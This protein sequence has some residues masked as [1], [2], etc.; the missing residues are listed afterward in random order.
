MKDV[1]ARVQR[2]LPDTDKDRYD[3]AYQRGRAQ[4]RSTLLAGGVAVGSALGAGLMWLLDPAKGAARRAQLGDRF[5]GLRN[6]VSSNVGGK[7]EDIGN[8]VSGFAIERGIKQPE[9]GSTD[10]SAGQGTTSSAVSH[11]GSYGDSPVG[12]ADT[13]QTVAVSTGTG[14]SGVGTVGTTSTTVTSTAAADAD[15]GEG[16]REGFG[17]T[18]HD[19]T[20]PGSQVPDPIQS[21]EITEYGSSGP[22]AGAAHESGT[23]IVS[24]QTQDEEA[25]AGR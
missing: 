17:A 3:I 2:E 13:G 11:P 21:D 5:N 9:D 15:Y 20:A 14:L 1:I 7:A 8:R 12:Q 18:E 16:Y 22:I 19:P 10:L 6:Q 25:A 23:S 4:A 24:S